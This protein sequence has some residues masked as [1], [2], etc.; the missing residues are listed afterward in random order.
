MEVRAVI[1]AKYSSLTLTNVCQ[2]STISTD[3]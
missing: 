1:R 2:I 3:T